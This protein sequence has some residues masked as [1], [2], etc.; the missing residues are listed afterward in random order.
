MG[1][2]V[3]HQRIDELFSDWNSKK[4][5]GLALGVISNGKFILKR[6]YGMA[7]IEEDMPITP[8]TIFSTASLSKQ[9]TAMCI[10]LLI[11]S[12]QISLADNIRKHLPELPRH[13]H[14]IAI[15]NLIYHTSGIP[16]YC[17]LLRIAGNEGEDYCTPQEVIELL[18]RESR[19]NFNPGAKFEYSNSNYFLLSQI[20]ERVSGKTLRDFAQENIFGPLGM[21][22]TQFHD[23]HKAIVKHVAEGYGSDKYGGFELSRTNMDTIGDGGILTNIEDMLLWDNNLYKNKLG[24]NKDKLMKMFLASGDLNNGTST[25]YAFG[26]WYMNYKGL[27]RAAHLG[28][29]AGYLAEYVRFPEKLFS[30]ICFSNVNTLDIMS[31]VDKICDLYLQ[32]YYNLKEYEGEYYNKELD[33]TYNILAEDSNLILI[34]K[35]YQ[36]QAMKI[37]DGDKFK[38]SDLTITFKRDKKIVTGFILDNEYVKSLKFVKEP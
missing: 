11:D 37:V 4:T 29:F 24:K 7:D 32:D 9:F 36:R 38:T 21:K 20:V 12:E 30:V 25:K 16:D 22:N 31:Y 26:L 1:K 8:K 3:I 6:A 19:L 14:K 2:S 35:H 13:S 18:K 33:A 27:K 17:E 5:P 15:N 10:A 28:E 34:K 23:N